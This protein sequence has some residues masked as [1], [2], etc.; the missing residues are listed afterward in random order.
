VVNHDGNL[1]QS[2]ILDSSET[3]RVVGVRA[4]GARVVV[5]EGL[6]IERANH[7]RTLLLNANA[8]PEVKVEPDESQK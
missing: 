3:Y 6:T 4:D 8:F 5:E 1:E 7:V 2:C